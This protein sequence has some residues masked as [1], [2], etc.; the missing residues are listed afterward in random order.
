MTIKTKIN[1]DQTGVSAVVVM[2]VILVVAVAGFAGWRVYNAKTD[3]TIN[4]EEIV[5]TDENNLG[6]KEQETKLPDSEPPNGWQVYSEGEITFFY[7]DDWELDESTNPDSLFIDL[8]SK[9]FKD[10]DGYYPSTLS[11]AN[12]I[13]GQRNQNGKDRIS[14]VED[15]TIELYE[16]FSEVGEKRLINGQEAIS[17]GVSYE[18]PPSFQTIIDAG[19]GHYYI[20]YRDVP[21]QDDSTDIVSA[22]HYE[23]YKQIVESF[24]VENKE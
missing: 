24:R 15:E 22:S 14:S 20:S 19:D 18:G 17:Y 9:D 8:K 6:D 13:I 4:N 7:P 23:V 5:A 16:Y 3:D 11:G 21:Y 1:L 12:I 10:D 2:I